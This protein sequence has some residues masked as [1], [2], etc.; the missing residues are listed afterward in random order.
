MVK[1]VIVNT[2]L[3]SLLKS[4]SYAIFKCYSI[5]FENSR[6]NTQNMISHLKHI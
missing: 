6:C 1:N 3:L 2:E 5:V 4:K